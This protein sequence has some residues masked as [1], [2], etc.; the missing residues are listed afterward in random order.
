[1]IPPNFTFISSE[2]RRREGREMSRIKELRDQYMKAEDQKKKAGE[3]ARAEMLANL[4]REAV[5]NGEL[6]DVKL[7][8]GKAEI[9]LPEAVERILKQMKDAGVG[10]IYFRG[11]SKNEIQKRS[12]QF[13][14]A[15]KRMEKKKG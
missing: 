15:K 3:K 5:A 1:L 4:L 12:R 6:T 8:N 9:L 10:N 11:A 7:L 2:E 14:S 13:I